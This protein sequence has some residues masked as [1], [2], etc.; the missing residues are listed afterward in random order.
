MSSSSS[1]AMRRG[2][3]WLVVAGVLVAAI[4]LRGPIVAPTPVLSDIEADLD[5]GSVA[6]GLLT[7]APVLMFAMLTPLAALVIRR[8]GAELALLLSLCGVLVGT[9]V[10]ALPGFGWMLA[11]MFVIGAFITIGNVVIPVV[12]RRDVPPERVAFVTAMYAA[13]LNVGSLV[14]SL[15]TAPLAGLIGWHAALMAWSVLTVVGIALWAVHMRT[16]RGT[17]DGLSGLQ[18]SPGTRDAASRETAG[19]VDAAT[20]TGPMPVVGAARSTRSI[21]RRPVSWL[22]VAAFGLQCTIYYGLTT[23]LPTIATDELGLSPTAAGAV[24][25]IFQG[26]GIAGAFVVPVLAR[27]A[28]RWVAPV[29]ICASWL[30]VTVGLI[31]APEWLWG[32]LAIGA[33]GHAGGFVVIFSTLVAVTR[34]DREAAGLSALVQGAGYSIGALGGPA[35]GALHEATGGWSLA[36]VVMLACAVAYCAALAGA[37]FTSARGAR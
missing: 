27:F 2:M 6:A 33:I 10:R 8:A 29:V 1:S 28:P 11:G 36:L 37:V 12:I 13:T 23:W 17:D 9:F 32:W 4:S 18:P 30:A 16:S 31:V 7:S 5:V 19:G 35:M 20:I 3:P 24:A 15:G 14:T 25:S 22:L 21:V 34:S 26:A